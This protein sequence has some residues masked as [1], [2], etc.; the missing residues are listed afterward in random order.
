MA[1]IIKELMTDC[2]FFIMKSSKKYKMF[3]FLSF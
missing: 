2:F 3:A 1:K